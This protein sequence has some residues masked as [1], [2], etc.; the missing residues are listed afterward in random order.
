MFSLFARTR[1]LGNVNTREADKYPTKE[2]SYFRNNGLAISTVVRRK[3][4]KGNISRSK[5]S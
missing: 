1:L 4:R 3:E 5:R 2:Y